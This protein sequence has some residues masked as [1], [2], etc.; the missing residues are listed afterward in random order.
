MSICGIFENTEIGFT[1]AHCCPLIDSR[2]AC[3]TVEFANHGLCL[4]LEKYQIRKN[5][6]HIKFPSSS[7]PHHLVFC[8]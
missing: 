5:R 2:V 7:L 8:L 3:K 4:D 6:V 1:V